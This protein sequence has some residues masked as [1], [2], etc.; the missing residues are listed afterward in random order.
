[1]HF[2]FIPPALIALAML[3]FS[4]PAFSAE[5]AAKPEDHT[6]DF[7]VLTQDFINLDVLFAQFVDPIHKIPTSGYISL[8]KRRGLMLGW[9]P[10]EG[11]LIGGG[12][13]R[14]AQ[15]G[16]YGRG[17]GE[18]PKISFDQVKYDE[19]R[20]DIN[21]QYQ[22]LANYLAPLRTTPPPGPTE[23]FVDLREVHP[24]PANAAEVKAALDL[25]DNEIKRM[26][27]ASAAHWGSA[28]PGADQQRISRVKQRREL[29]GRQFT[30]ARW[31]E[32]V[33]EMNS[34]S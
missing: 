33:A 12:G 21:Q 26:E 3:G 34:E 28:V 10:P 27:K 22:R 8:L 14:G 9:K 31:N 17:G 24:N 19:L 7:K 6:A 32:L 25:V 30:Q 4:A 15:G 1:M 29:L 11:M 18:E 2:R 5:E 16:A 20:Y 13:G 23:L